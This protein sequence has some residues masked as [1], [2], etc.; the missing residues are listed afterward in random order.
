MPE[1][2]VIEVKSTGDDAWL[3][4][5]TPQ[6]SKYFGAYRLVIVTNIR[7]FLIVGE[8]ADGKPAKLEGFRLAPDAAAFWG[9]IATPKKSA[10]K[11]GQAFG[12]FL[13]RALTS[14][15]SRISRFADA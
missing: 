1:R 6:V 9:M 7:D 10:Q 11:I 4:A 5:A 12:E 13:K 15:E 8:G 14:T 2:G 3:T